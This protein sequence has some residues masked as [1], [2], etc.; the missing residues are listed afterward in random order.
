M[1]K[2]DSSV[3]PFTCMS[4]KEYVASTTI[5]SVRHEQGEMDSKLLLCNNCQ[6]ELTR[7]IIFRRSKEAINR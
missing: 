1:I 4:C 5:I 6:L 2:L 3:I 7:R